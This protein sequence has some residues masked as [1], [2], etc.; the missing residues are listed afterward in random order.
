LQYVLAAASAI[1]SDVELLIVASTGARRIDAE[2]YMFW[3]GRVQR[4]V[5][6][7]VGGRRRV[8]YRE[9]VDLDNYEGKIVVIANWYRD[10]RA[11]TGT[12]D[13]DSVYVPKEPD[14]QCYDIA[15]VLAPV[16]LVSRKV[17]ASDGSESCEYT[18][19]KVDRDALDAAVGDIAKSEAP[20]RRA[21]GA[22]AKRK[23]SQ[24][25]PDDGRETSITTSA[26]GR[27]MITTVRYAN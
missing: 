23:H 15:H 12:P 20:T 19:S 24:L 27:A 16:T 1:V 2:P 25:M 14:L 13:V 6:L 9:P 17:V 22:S 8:E 3:L 18:L 26:R 21:R 7:L 11:V 10:V 4:L 5:K